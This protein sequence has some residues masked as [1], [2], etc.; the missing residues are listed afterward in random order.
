M[1]LCSQGHHQSVSGISIGQGPNVEDRVILPVWPIVVGDQQ[2]VVE[3][4]QTITGK[5]LP[6]GDDGGTTEL[7]KSHTTTD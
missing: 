3:K 6:D 4:Y 1:S 2:V 7:I 5:E